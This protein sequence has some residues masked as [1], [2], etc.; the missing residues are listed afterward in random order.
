MNATPTKGA[1][2]GSRSVFTEFGPY[3]AKRTPN[4]VDFSDVEEGL[5]KKL[6]HWD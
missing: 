2:S 6:I 3:L 1:Y 5:R 4:R